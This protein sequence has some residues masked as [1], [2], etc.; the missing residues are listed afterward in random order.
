MD[1][2]VAGFSPF[3]FD[4]EPSY[5]PQMVTGF[6]DMPETL[7]MWTEIGT[8]VLDNARQAAD[9][10]LKLDERRLEPDDTHVCCM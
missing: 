3:H 10:R 7:S 8:K 2:M 4:A 5:P 1:S 6:R 9:R